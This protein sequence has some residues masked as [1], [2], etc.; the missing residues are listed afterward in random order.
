MSAC[1]GCHTATDTRRSPDRT[2][3]PRQAANKAWEPPS[4]TGGRRRPR[5]N[6]R[7]GGRHGATK[8]R[9][10][11]RDWA[12]PPRGRGR[13]ARL[14]LRP[15]GCLAH[16]AGSAPVRFVGGPDGPGGVDGVPGPGPAVG[17]GGERLGD[18]ELVEFDGQGLGRLVEHQGARFGEGGYRVGQGPLAAIV[19]SASSRPSTSPRRSLRIVAT[20][21]VGGIHDQGRSCL[22]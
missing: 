1:G 20:R 10:G 2:R 3:H 8:K 5:P 11:R 22:I 12:A 7:A 6:L 15:L 4:I 13:G 9:R 16:A 21:P 19:A 18:A 14:E 17:A